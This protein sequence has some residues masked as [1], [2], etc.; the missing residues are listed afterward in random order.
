MHII[1]RIYET[2]PIFHDEDNVFIP[3]ANGNARNKGKYMS[4]KN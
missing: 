4:T 1:S 3:S 2:F